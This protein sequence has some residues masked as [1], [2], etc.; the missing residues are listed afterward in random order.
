MSDVNKLDKTQ[1]PFDPEQYNVGDN[2]ITVP[3]GTSAWALSLVYLGKQV[4]RSGWNAPIEHM[5]LAHKSEVGNTDDGVAYIEKSDKNGY[6]SHWMPTQEDLM[7]CDW[8]LVKPE[9]KP[10]TDDCILSFDLNIGT[11]QY[12]SSF[13]QEWG[14]LPDDR[15]LNVGESTF[16]TLTNFKSTLGAISISSFTL[17]EA[18]IGTFQDVELLLDNAI[19]PE[20]RLNSK[21]FE[22]TINGS[23]YNL[24]SSF[25]TAYN[26]FIYASD[27]AKQLGDFLK[28]NVGKTLSFCFNWK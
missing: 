22:V 20:L 2:N 9:I 17:K 1:C 19:K 16:G 14:Y 4:Y 27:G 23:T 5:R 10:E 15:D 21:N 13:G 12:F 6:W 18:P 28:Q 7:A 25:G 26:E 11:S 8:V 3:A 24:G